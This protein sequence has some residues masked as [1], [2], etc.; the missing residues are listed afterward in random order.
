MSTTIA[1]FVHID[2]QYSDW[3]GHIVVANSSES[4]AS[5]VRERCSANEDDV[6]IVV[7][8]ASCAM[9]GSPTAVERF[10]DDARDLA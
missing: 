4:A 7:P 8:L 3:T 2:Q 6:C 5:Q 9:N 10:H 1:W